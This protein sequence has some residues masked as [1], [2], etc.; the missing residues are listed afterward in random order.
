MQI[1]RKTLFT[2][3]GLVAALAIGFGAAKLS[4]RASPPAEAGE[5]AEAAEGAKADFVKLTAEQARNAGVAVV[6]VAQGGAADIRLSGRVE[7]APEARAVI[8]APVSGS[9]Q[10]VLVSPGTQVS[11]GAALVLI[12]SADGATVR[13]E[14]VAANAD[15]E[16]ARAALAR[17]ERLLNEGVVARQDWEAARATSV[18]ATAQAAA[19][20]ARVAAAGG[21]DADGLTAV[22]SP[23][24]GLV[25]SL[26]TAP[27]GFV[28]QGGPVAE[29]SNPAR[30]E[31]VFN[32][33]PEAA[34]RV[35]A[36]APLKIISAD[37]SEADA[38]IIG[39]APMAM[40][41]T[42]GAVVRARPTGGR[43]TPGSAV[44][45]SVVST[46]ETLPTVPAEAVQTVGGRSVVFIA[47]GQGFRV[48]PV[49][50]GRSGGGY[51]QI[52]TGLRGGERVAGRGAFLLKA[53]LS[54][55]EGGD[56]D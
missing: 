30:V 18:R 35:K 10:R 25:T 9:V 6:A 20:R 13:A 32:A 56:E 49:T 3:A 28:S 8:A 7:P 11:A 37:G 1:D 29:V 12:R 44:S 38:I 43:L 55:G 16:A 41:S 4:D 46:G 23:I 34:A 40:G 22:R 15:A 24:A 51:T 48:S 26:Q 33:P 31:V 53:E 27:G 36:G 42:G 54:K 52:V 17:E 14:A 45:A 21:P 2:G 50:P 47:E 39:V 5:E 19:A